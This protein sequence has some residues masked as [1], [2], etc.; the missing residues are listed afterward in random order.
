[1]TCGCTVTKLRNFKYM[2]VA[3]KIAQI[4]DFVYKSNANWDFRSPNSYNCDYFH[5]ND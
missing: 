1:M 2:H 5:F 4:C 3:P